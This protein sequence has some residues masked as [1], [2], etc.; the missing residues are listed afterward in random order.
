MMKR[1]PTIHCSVS[2]S[3]WTVGA[4]ALRSAY[5]KTTRRSTTPFRRAI[6]T[7]SDDIAS[8]TPARTMRT[9]KPTAT[10][11]IVAT[12]STSTSGVAS[13][14]A[15][16][17]TREIGGSQVAQIEKIR[18]SDEPTTKSGRAMKPSVRPETTWSGVRP[19]RTPAQTPSAMAIGIMTSRATSASV[20]VFAIGPP[21]K[22]E[23]G[24]WAPVTESPKLPCSRSRSQWT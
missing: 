2:A 22:D 12:G 5:L 3:T 14:L 11:T 4:S 24:S 10:T 19:A 13:G 23:T 15:P 21:I 18:I 17:A 20:T 9:A 16:G 6:W 8:I 1:P 7:Y